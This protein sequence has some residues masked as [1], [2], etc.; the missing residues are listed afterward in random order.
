MNFELVVDAISNQR[1]SV[2]AIGVAATDWRTIEASDPLGYIGVQV[3][4]S[5]AA[6][7]DLSV[8]DPFP[9]NLPYLDGET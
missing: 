4:V 2:D 5:A 3:A 9:V 7:G 6:L 1:P 8:G